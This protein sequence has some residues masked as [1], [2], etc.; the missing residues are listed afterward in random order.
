MK[1]RVDLLVVGM[2]RSW[3]VYSAHS[4]RA[5]GKE[6]AWIAQ[7]VERLISRTGSI[8][9]LDSISRKMNGFQ[10]RKDMGDLEEDLNYLR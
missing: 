4:R 1:L 9:P 2:G 8:R 5:M 10:S 6:R 7:T 3:V